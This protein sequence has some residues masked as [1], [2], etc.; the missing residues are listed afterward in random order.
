[1]KTTTQK[2][3][4]KSQKFAKKIS[5][6]EFH[7]NQT[8]FLRFKVILLMIL[9]LMTLWNF[10]LKVYLRSWSLLNLNYTNCILIS[11]SLN[12]LY[13][14]RLIIDI[15][16]KIYYQ[17]YFIIFTFYHLIIYIFYNF[18][19]GKFAKIKIESMYKTGLSYLFI[20][21]NDYKIF[22]KIFFWQS[23]HFSAFEPNNNPPKKYKQFKRSP[24]FH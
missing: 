14:N 19:E 17:F 8:I 22:Y 15:L 24:P 13:S 5:A 12:F 9:K 23:P 1:M 4:S 3:L 11:V 2:N 16:I 18:Y 21:Y 6:V 7:Y 10:N 20:H